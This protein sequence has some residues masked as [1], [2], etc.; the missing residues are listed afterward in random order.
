MSKPRNK[1]RALDGIL[2][3]D[4]PTGIS[5]NAA[6]QIAKRFYN[7]QKAGHTGSLDP[8]AS[9]MLPICFGEATK[10]SQFLLEADK[11]YE[12]TAKLGVKT[13]TG[14]AEGEV[15]AEKQ[16]PVVTPDMIEKLFT[17]FTGTLQQIPSMYSAIKQN[18]QPLY[19]L[20]RQGI[21][22]VREPRE[23]QIYSLTYLSQTPDTLSFQIHSS[24]GTYVR[25]LVEDM[26][27]ALGCGAH[28]QTL[29]R[30][31]VGPYQETQMQTLEHLQTLAEKQ[32]RDVMDSYLLP[33]DSMIQHWPELALSE[34]AIYYLKQG[35]PVI[36]PY[37][38]TSGW[39]RITRKD[40]SFFGVGEVLDDGRIAPRRLVQ[41]N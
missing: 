41:Q 16:P 21:E 7:A 14:D 39:L 26:G 30:P 19:K 3:L 12:V 31:A 33:V 25:T 6:L 20:A 32:A 9:G 2:L 23:I 36:A 34:A 13:T 1:G 17:Q 11:H 37:A 10:F 22:V 4:K 28:V 24:K 29:R 35:Q 15:L 18:G 27:E 40:G 5:S 8:L 38:P